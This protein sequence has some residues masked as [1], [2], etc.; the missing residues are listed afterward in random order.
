[1]LENRLSSAEVEV[2]SFDH[3]RE[4]CSH[5]I[6]SFQSS[7]I[8]IILVPKAEPNVP[9]PNKFKELLSSTVDSPF[10]ILLDVQRRR[11]FLIWSHIQY[12]PIRFTQGL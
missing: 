11:A 2:A 5:I 9:G 8:M 12:Y 10:P 1:M 3:I 7:Q 4:V 6:Q